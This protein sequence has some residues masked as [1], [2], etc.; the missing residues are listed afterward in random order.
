MATL[1]MD[2]SQQQP[3]TDITRV[4]TTAMTRAT[5]FDIPLL[6]DLIARHLTTRDVYKCTLVSHQF[7]DA[8]QHSLYTCISIH[9]EATLDMFFRNEAQ[10]AFARHHS[11]VK[12]VSTSFGSCV[13]RLVNHIGYP[14][15]LPPGQT[16]TSIVR[17]LTVLRYEPTNR[18]PEKDLESYSNSILSLITASPSLQVLH[19]AYFSYSYSSLILGLAKVVREKGRR[20]REL[21]LYPTETLLAP[22]IF[23]LLWSCAAVEVLEM[24]YGPTFRLRDHTPHAV[25]TLPELRAFAREALSATSTKS[26][27]AHV[28]ATEMT[29]LSQ[30]AE[31]IEFAWKELGFRSWLD[32]PK[33][34]EILEVLR[35]CPN[36]E[37]IVIPRLIEQDVVTHLA[38]AVAKGMPQLRHLDFTHISNQPLGTRCLVESCKDLISLNMEKLRQELNLIL[39]RC[40]RL[41]TLNATSWE[42]E[43]AEASPILNTHDMAMV[44]EEPGWVCKDIE[45]LQLCYSGVDTSV[46]VPEV[47]WRQIGQLSKLK[48]LK[49][50]RHASSE[51]VDVQENESVRQAVSSWATLSD[52]RRLELRALRAFVDKAMFTHVQ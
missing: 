28:E 26:H 21:R 20:L 9:Q 5:V 30:D 18:P 45:T 24:G 47:L 29:E 51:I 49:L 35:M 34:E 6:V 52:L 11:Q 27:P 23:T 19:L 36:L 48:D 37:R 40:R 1:Q 46:G 43:T 17:N 13:A 41:K 39:S 22:R 12:E 50:H 32:D 31:R 16:L 7:H 8:F 15:D 38:P 3:V 44:P 2:A 14:L 4:T 42:R 33:L 10:V 25:E